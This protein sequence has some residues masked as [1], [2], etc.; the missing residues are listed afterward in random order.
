MYK[1]YNRFKKEKREKKKGR[2]KKKGKKRETSTE[3]QKPNVK[4]EVY[5]NNRMCE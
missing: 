4:P 3:L 1:K 5:N 2:R